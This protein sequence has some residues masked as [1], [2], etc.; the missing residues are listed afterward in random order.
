MDKNK[1]TMI[2]AKKEYQLEVAITNKDE[3]RAKQIDKELVVLNSELMKLKL[4]GKKDAY[5]KME[6]INN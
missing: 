5:K 1:V 2:I 6:H 4:A 3:A